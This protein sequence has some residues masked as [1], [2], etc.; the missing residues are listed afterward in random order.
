MN[1]IDRKEIGGPGP[2]KLKILLLKMYVKGI[3]FQWNDR[4][5]RGVDV[6]L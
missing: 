4:E 6:F 1:Q 2:Y 3:F 5:N